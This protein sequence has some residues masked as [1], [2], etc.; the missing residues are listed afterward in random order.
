MDANHGGGGAETRMVC[1]FIES[2]E[3]LFAPLFRSLP[4]LLVERADEDRIGAMIASTVRESSRWS[5]R[6]GRAR[7]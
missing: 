7:R 1:G 5:T 4:E 2:S 6:R 3:F